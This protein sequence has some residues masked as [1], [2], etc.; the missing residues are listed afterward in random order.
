M[1]TIF[2]F[3]TALIVHAVY[4]YNMVNFIEFIDYKFFQTKSRNFTIYKLLYK[5]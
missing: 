4:Q 5:Q 3:N 2:R 1:H